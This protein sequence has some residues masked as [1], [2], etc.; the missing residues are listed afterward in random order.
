M[1]VL[2]VEVLVIGFG[3]A[4]KTI[5]MKRAAAGDKVALVEQ[6]PAMYGGTC[7]NIA[8]VPTKHLLTSAAKGLAF[9]Q[10][11]ENRNTFIAKVNAAN[12][13]MAEGKGVLV[14]DGFAQFTA[15]HTV[16]VGAELSITGKTVIINTGAVSGITPHGKVH[17]STSIQQLATTPEKLAIVGAG[18]IG[19][20]FATMFNQFGS[21]VTVYNGMPT[22]LP[23][24]DPE[25]AQAV[26]EHLTSQGIKIVNQMVDDFESLDAD[27]VLLA[28]GRKPA[29]ADLNLAAAGIAYTDKGIEVDDH[30]RTNV[31]G[32]YAVG[33]VTGAP[34]FTYISYDD[35]RVVLSDRWGDGSYTRKGRIFPTTT[36]LNPP[37]STIGMTEAA[38][39]ATH[40]VEIRQA[41]IADMA[42]VP[43]P[44]IVGNPAGLAKFILDAHTNQILGATLF[45]ID[46]QELINTV[47]VAMTNQIPAQILGDGIYTHPATSEIFNAL[48]A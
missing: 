28:I 29:V 19:L 25:V 37:L 6:S 43:R 33:D 44:K 46:S 41:N 12:K 48:L 1:E 47:A 35:H 4:G 45:C 32:V 26:H 27:A 42:I 15:S 17:D 11:K 36:F 14:V 10:A 5:A 30:C 34:Q 8:C 13:Q 24:F 2:E 7:V 31:P 3:K 16:Q 18:P 38:A 21:E 40:E 22:F 9:L 20:E 23:N 39:R